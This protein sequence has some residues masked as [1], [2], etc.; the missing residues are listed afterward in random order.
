MKT[1]LHPYINFNGQCREAMQFYQQCL[2]GDLTLQ[3]LAESPMAAQMPAA[4]NTD[5]L[6]SILIHHQVV[7][8]GSDMMGAN[9]KR[10]NGI[11][12]CLQ[13]HASDEA[14]TMF[15]ALSR[16]GQIQTPLHQTF[17]GATYG[18]LTD[19]YGVQWMVQFSK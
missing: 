13:C 15:D 10:G 18:E 12:L 7:I 4:R 5:I 14:H 16:N 3:P 1:T 11:G 17:W 8:M 6:H 2:G 19:Q 9:L